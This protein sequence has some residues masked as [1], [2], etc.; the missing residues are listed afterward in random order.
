MRTGAFTLFVLAL[1]VMA[2]C[3][4]SPVTPGRR[5]ARSKWPGGATAGISLIDLEVRPNGPAAEVYGGH[6]HEPHEP[7]AMEQDLVRRLEKLGLEHDPALGRMAR[8]LAA[9]TPSRIDIP[10]G[11][12]D[13]LM[14]WVGLVDPP[15]RLVVAE[16]PRDMSGCL[17]RVTRECSEA[18]GT[19]VAQVETSVPRTRELSFGVGVAA[20]GSGPSRLVAAIGEHGVE[21][22]PF[23]VE[24][25]PGEAVALRGRLLGSRA[26][27]TVEMVDPRGR[28]SRVPVSVESAGRFSTRVGC[29]RGSGV[30]QVEVLA[31]GAHGPEV[32]ANFPLYC[33]VRPQDRIRV[34]VERVDPSITADEI[35][36]VNFAYLNEARRIRGLEELVWDAAAADVA[37]AHSRDMLENGFVGHHSP[38]TGDIADRF[39]AAGIVSTVIRE[40][41]ARGYGPKGIHESLMRSPGHRVN[42]VAEDVT[43]VGIGIVVAPPEVD[44]EDAPRPLLATQAFLR[45]PGA[46][47]LR[48]RELAGDLRSR[49]DAL[50][51]AAGLRALRWDDRLSLLAQREARLAAGRRRGRKVSEKEVFALGYAA[52]ERHQVQSIDYEA[53]SRLDLWSRVDVDYVGIGVASTAGDDGGAGFVLIVFVVER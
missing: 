13:A 44:V 38:T 25:R 6:E 9:I 51:L 40:N 10:P 39:E 26:R 37:R 34:E 35:A 47:G 42:I 7:T 15:P 16:I 30:Y 14:S 24:V 46:V 5:T 2:H 41:V 4:E 12:V 22:E 52:L 3:V 49:V 43:H 45:K 20:P 11:L 1:I 28:W 50:R 27:P 21:L 8:E 53:L 23:P 33:A 18:I 19:L 17:A 32:V 36:R 29:T 31:D 48:E